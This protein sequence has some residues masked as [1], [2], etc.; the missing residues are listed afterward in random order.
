M[1]IRKPNRVTT[2]KRAV[3]NGARTNHAS[4]PRDRGR[5]RPG[6]ARVSAPADD[7]ALL[8]GDGTRE[9]RL[10]G[11]AARVHAFDTSVA[12][13]RRRYDGITFVCDEAGHR[14]AAIVPVTVAEFA[15][16]HGALR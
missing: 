10:G 5:W 16:H 3:L 1:T 15:I 13:A 14:I 8:P 2:P 9:V 7:P 4:M 6:S 11:A 12:D